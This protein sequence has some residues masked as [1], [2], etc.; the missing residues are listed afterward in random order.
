VEPEE[1]DDGDGGGS[2]GRKKVYTNE[3]KFFAGHCDAL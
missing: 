1:Q 3:Q 2:K